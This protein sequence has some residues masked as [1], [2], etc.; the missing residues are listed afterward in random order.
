MKVI[1]LWV[2]YPLIRPFYLLSLILNTLV[3]SLVIIVISPF[4]RNGR[5]VH[6]IGKFW[7]MLN[8]Y[9]PGT[10]VSLKGKEK[11]AKNG[12]Y[13]IMSNHQSLLDPWVLIAKLPLQLRWVI[14]SN[15]RKVP[16]F[17][18]ALERMGHIYVD[19]K[20][21]KS[22]V[23]SLEIAVQQSKRGASIV[24]FPEG[25]RSQ[26]GNLLKFHRGG[27]AIAAR[28]AVPILPLT[29]NGS[30]FVLPKNTLALMPGKI[31][32]IVGDPIDPGEFKGKGEEA[33]L[34]AVRTAIEKNQDLSYGDLT[35]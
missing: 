34:E 25:T 20:S 29:I 31:K 18:Y 15:V 23:R 11:I 5:V 12:T 1:L 7:S 9:L 24:I 6:Y 22:M 10:R 32:V 2:F 13:V 8:L 17:G 35:L 19:K 28:A 27:A 21:R 33:L 3:L 30:R 16:V 14:R 26:D 4:D